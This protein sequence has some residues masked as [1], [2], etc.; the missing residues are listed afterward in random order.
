M[1]HP[2]ESKHRKNSARLLP[3]AMPSSVIYVGESAEDFK[4]I[5]EQFGSQQAKACIFYPHKKSTELEHQL[6]LYQAANF[7]ALIFIDATWRKAYKMWQLNTWL[8]DLPSWHFADPPNSQ[9]KIRSTKITNGI[10]TLE[11]ASYALRLG[12]GINTQPLLEIFE[13]MQSNQLKHL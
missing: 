5:K 6:E 4:T 7:D 8:H 13:A 9:Y 10:S 1:Q 2:N 11:A 3:L 12:H